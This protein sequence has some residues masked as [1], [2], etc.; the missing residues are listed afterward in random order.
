MA[1][2]DP[3]ALYTFLAE[4]GIILK[5]ELDRV[6]TE[7]VQLGKPFD[8]VL[9]ESEVIS[10]ENLGKAIA[11]ITKTPFVTLSKIAIPDDVL[12]LIP[13][14]VARKELVIAYGK[15]EKGLRVAMYN[16]DN[17]AVQQ[18]I[19][20]TTGW[21]LIVCYATKK[22][23][24]DAASKYAT[25][26]VQA[27]TDILSDAAKKSATADAP[28]IAIVDTIIKN[29]YENKVSDIHIEPYEHTSLV[30]FRIDGI[31]HDIVRLP[32]PLH[33]QI[34]TRIKVM[35]KMRTDEHQAAQDGKI[36]FSL[37][38]EKLD[39]RVSVVPIEE[40]E[41]VVMR[42][43]SERSRQ[44]TL[45]DLGFSGKD[46]EKLEKAAKKPYGMILVTGPTGSGK[47][48]SLYAIL[49]QL[50]K[51]SINIMTIEDPVE[52]DIVGVNQIQVNLKTN[53]TFAAGL[54]SIVRQDPDIILVGEIRDEETAGIAVNSAMTG[55]LVLSTLHA[56][57]AATTFPRFSTLR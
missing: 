31:L 48:T 32:N 25:N 19:A 21:P 30:R 55:H 2:Y 6:Y 39:I 16:P 41:K 47:T 52:Y 10:D 40:G 13:E 33:D 5:T 50:N 18:L 15:D 43:L 34:I 20:K 36:S 37:G 8:E 22:D 28:I 23:I 27:F 53:L 38:E 46:F 49:K 29:G 4:L 7:S 42:L 12:R 17:L 56:N 45:S 54:K 44:Y 35:S 9:L 1:T 11:D 26:A 57:D 14:V 24:E 3:K 51:R